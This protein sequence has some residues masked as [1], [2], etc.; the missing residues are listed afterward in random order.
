M[1]IRWCIDVLIG[2]VSEQ[3]EINEWDL[4]KGR[5]EPRPRNKHS[6]HLRC[7]YL[8]SIIHPEVLELQVD[9]DKV[10]NYA[11]RS[12][13]VRSIL[14]THPANERHSVEHFLDAASFVCLEWPLRPP[15]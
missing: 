5:K 8:Y 10:V 9:W 13:Q 12:S 2:S 11:R 1:I 15:A 7:Q 3:K 14:A 4:G 6:L